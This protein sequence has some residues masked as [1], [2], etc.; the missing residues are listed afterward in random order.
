MWTESVNFTVNTSVI[1]GDLKFHVS[2]KCLII[3]PGKD[4]NE[5]SL[6]L[7][8]C[9]KQIELFDVSNVYKKRFEHFLKLKC[10]SWNDKI[11]DFCELSEK[12]SEKNKLSAEILQA[13]NFS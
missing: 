4:R 5:L 1:P 11:F 12:F 2:F 6:A 8:I 13:T 10:S 7:K 3:R 9:C